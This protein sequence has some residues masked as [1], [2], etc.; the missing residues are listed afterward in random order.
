MSGR[1]RWRGSA[2]IVSGGGSGV[3]FAVCRRLAAAGMKLLLVGRDAAKLR[4]ARKVLATKTEAAVIAGDVGCPDFC[5]RVVTTADKRFGDLRLLVNAAGAMHRG[6]AADTPNEAWSR[7]MRT[8][9][10]G[11]FY[12]SRDAQARMRRGGAIVNVGS[13]LSLVGAPG[14]AAYCASK[15]AVAQL[16]RAMALDL[17][18]RGITVNAV[19]PG[20]VDAP[21]LYAEHPDG[22][23]AEEVRRRNAAIIPSKQLA[24]ADDVARAVI[25]LAGEPHI[26]GALLS[27]DGGYVA[28]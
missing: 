25:F 11:V 12:L 14:L 10:D 28:Q 24:T 1:R 5:A 3:G 2:A 20:A 16:T 17:A 26:T 23:R 13:T 18:A 9:A 8:N 22:T 21:M 7:L 6:D 27:V 15:G 19:C 4:R